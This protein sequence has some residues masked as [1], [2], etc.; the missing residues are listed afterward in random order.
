[1]L[2]AAAVFA[3]G[4]WYRSVSHPSAGN[5][6]A[7][8]AWNSSEHAA[9][10]NA[11]RLAQQPGIKGSQSASPLASAAANKVHAQIQENQTKISA[12]DQQI[13]SS[14]E[15]KATDTQDRL[16]DLQQNIQQQRDRVAAL[17]SQRQG[18]QA[19]LTVRQS[20]QQSLMGSQTA[21]VQQKLTTL[22]TEIDQQRQQAWIAEQEVRNTIA[23]EG[24]DNLVA[25]QDY[26]NKQDEKLKGLQDQYSGLLQQQSA[27]ATQAY[28]NENNRI[29]TQQA[30]QVDLNVAATQ[31][32]AELDR[33]SQEY[34]QLSQKPAAG[35]DNTQSL[36]SQKENLQRETQDLQRRY[37]Q[38]TGQSSP[39]G[40][41]ST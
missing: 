36:V 23:P 13:Q 2:V 29:Q 28:A 22:Q 33:L 9:T 10:D 27:I 21:L 30:G 41:P 25:L 6:E 3:G 35:P 31:A 11:A 39:P 26:A 1:M 40:T 8:S 15:N 34:Q 14:R 4:Y 24:S 18:S 5:E 16:A 7:G 32:Q 19:D 17:E 12:L 38:L 20:N 37:T